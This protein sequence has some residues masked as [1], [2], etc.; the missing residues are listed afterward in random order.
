MSTRMDFTGSVRTFAELAAQHPNLDHFHAVEVWTDS[1][2]YEREEVH[3]L[4][5]IREGGVVVEVGDRNGPANDVRANV[6]TRVVG[7]EMH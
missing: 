5:I 3:H 6:F 2:G 4:G 1:A 7:D